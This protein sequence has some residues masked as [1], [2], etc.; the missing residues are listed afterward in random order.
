MECTGSNLEWD[1]TRC[2]LRLESRRSNGR[3]DDEQVVASE[4]SDG[5]IGCYRQSFISDSSSLTG[6]KKELILELIIEIKNQ[7]L[8]KRKRRFNFNYSLGT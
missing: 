6:K 1:Q 3:A 5:A 4:S 2:F 7:E 8:K